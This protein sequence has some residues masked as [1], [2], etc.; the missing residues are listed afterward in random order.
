MDLGAGTHR[1]AGEICRAG[2]SSPNND[3]NELLPMPP[4]TALR[5]MLTHCGPTTTRTPRLTI[6]TGIDRGHPDRGRR[7]PGDK[8]CHQEQR[9]VYVFCG[10]S[11]E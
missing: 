10:N 8:S 4:V 6:P 7:L 2:C 9:A 1:A 5:W 3:P 11:Q